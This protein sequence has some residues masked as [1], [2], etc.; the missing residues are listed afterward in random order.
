MK[1]K[2][3]I[4]NSEKLKEWRTEAL[5]SFLDLD[6][7]SGGVWLAGGAIRS[8]LAKGDEEISDFDLFF[9]DFDVVTIIREKLIARGAVLVYECPEGKLYTYKFPNIPIGEDKF[10]LGMKIQL[11]T[12]RKYFSPQDIISSFDFGAT[13]GVF[14]GRYFYIHTRMVKD[15]TSR[16]LSLLNLTYP[17]ATLK[18]I[19]KYSKKGYRTHEV[20]KQFVEMLQRQII[21]NGSL[22]EDSLRFY[23]D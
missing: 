2:I 6:I 17:V 14:D 3:F 19:V 5:N 1:D 13:C 4:F 22:S 23:I 16:T 12:E 18:R 21:N 10:E 11:I 7:L 20:S 15:V 9:S 8:I